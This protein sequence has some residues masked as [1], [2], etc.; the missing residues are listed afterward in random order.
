MSDKAKAKDLK[1]ERKAL[2]RSLVRIRAKGYHEM[3]GAEEFLLGEATRQLKE[4][5]LEER[6]KG[7]RRR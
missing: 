7:P 4:L 2:A 5:G 1:I 3:G 6:A